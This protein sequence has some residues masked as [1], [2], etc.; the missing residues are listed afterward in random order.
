MEELRGIMT[1]IAFLARQQDELIV[2]I[3]ED[4]SN[5]ELHVNRAYSEL[6]QYIPKVTANRWLYLKIFAILVVFM[7]LFIVFFV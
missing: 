4:I 6:L 2:R 3:D 1:Q 5:T 7:V